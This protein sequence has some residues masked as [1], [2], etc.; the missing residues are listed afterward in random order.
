MR[1]LTISTSLLAGLVSLLAATP[2]AYACGGLFCSAVQPVNQAAERI[3]FATNADDTVT[4]VIE[5]QYAGPSNEFSWL[6]PIGAVPDSLEVSSTQAFQR[7]Q[8]ATNPQYSLTTRV[9]GTCKERS[10]SFISG[11]AAVSDASP[12][13]AVPPRGVVNVEASGSVG[14]FDW[15]VLSVADDVADPARAAVDWLETAGYDVPESAPGLLGP[16]LSDGL[17]LLALKLT[18]GEDTG[19]IRPIVVTYPGDTPMI[20]LR[21]TSVAANPDMGVMTWLL[22][23]GRGV[24]KNYLSLEL[25]EAR[26]NWFNPGSNYNA[27][28]I[29]AANDAGGQGFVTEYSDAASTLARTVWTDSEEANWQSFTEGT[30]GSFEDMYRAAEQNWSNYDG[31]IDALEQG[32]TLSASVSREDFRACPGCYVDQVEFSPSKLVTALEE[33]VIQPMRL[34]QDLL[35]VA[36]DVTRL[37]TTLSADEMTVDPVFTFNTSLP[38]VSNIHTAERVVECDSGTYISDAPFHIVLPQGDVV[39]GRPSDVNSGVWPAALASLPSNRLVSRQGDTGSG[40]VAEDNTEEIS[41]QLAAYNS[42]IPGPNGGCGCAVVGTR[43]SEAG[44][45]WLA[46]GSLL[47]LRRGGSRVRGSQ[48]RSK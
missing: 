47:A 10:S 34:V 35:D 27:L 15:A 31:Y 48:S 2:P 38:T 39:R 20:P 26:I 41:E 5:I 33:N 18:K 11:N 36:P 8:A 9:E 22:G 3:I 14:P 25:N 21:P 46:L 24:P 4:A 12:G 43:R 37:Y 40:R 16:Y 42:T 44:W 32:V 19:A 7:L 17:Y 30:Y 1:H 23:E 28:V 13:I 6:L 29:E 45:G